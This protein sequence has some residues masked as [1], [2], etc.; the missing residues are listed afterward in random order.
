MYRLIKYNLR[1]IYLPGKEM[2][3]ADALS[4]ASIVDKSVT[5]VEDLRVHSIT[6]SLP[7]SEE[8]INDFVATENDEILRQSKINV[9]NGWEKYKK[10]PKDLKIYYNIRNEITE[11]NNLLF[12]GDRLIVPESK[13]NFILLKI[14]VGHL[15]IYKCRARAKECLFRP[16]MSKDIHDLI[17][18][19]EICNRF[20]KGNARLPML[21]HK[22][23]DRP[24][25]K[26]GIDIF[27]FE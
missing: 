1:V 20:C 9:R 25:C 6:K 26:I 5:E 18:K 23:P 16:N 21:S 4:R 24:W 15:G 17:V 22:I 19:C 11:C 7:M 2:H 27:D 12:Y 14:H 10:L 13:R 3:I 8:R